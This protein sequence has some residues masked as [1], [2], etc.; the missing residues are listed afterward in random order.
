MTIS[1]VDPTAP[2]GLMTLAE[3]SNTAL[4]LTLSPNTPAVK[5]TLTEVNVASGAWDATN[6]VLTLATVEKLA[7]FSG[8]GTTL[9]AVIADEMWVQLTQTVGTLV[10]VSFMDA[11]GNVF[12]F[13]GVDGSTPV[14]VTLNGVGTNTVPTVYGNEG[15]VVGSY[16]TAYI[17]EPTSTTLSLL[18]LAALAVRRRRR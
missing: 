1:A 7:D 8:L 13:D 17:P 2:A 11:E 18:A 6:Q 16:M 3:G 4:V 14:N 5:P 12:D 9:N 15:T 10:D